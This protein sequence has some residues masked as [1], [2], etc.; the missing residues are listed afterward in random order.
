MPFM[1]DKTRK[2]LF[3]QQKKRFLKKI[4]F[5]AGKS[6]MTTNNRFESSQNAENCK[7]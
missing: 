3:L 6:R 5:F 2:P 1:L 7:T 4:D